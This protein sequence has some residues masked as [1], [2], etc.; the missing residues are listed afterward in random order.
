[1]L[2]VHPLIPGTRG[3]PPD[4]FTTV[5]RVVARRQGA[6]RLVEEVLTYGAVLLYW[7]ADDL[8]I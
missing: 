6:Q 5:N 1:M 7:R 3:A 8:C 2:L 4:G